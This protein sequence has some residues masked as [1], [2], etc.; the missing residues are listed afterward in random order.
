MI[1]AIKIIKENTKIGDIGY[2]IQKN[3][4]AEG[5]SVVREFC[6]HGIGKRFHESSNILHYKKQ[7][8]GQELKAGIIL[9]IE[10][11]VNT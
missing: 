5:F 8:T 10:P 7:N 6:G 11:M 2:T 4:E 9:T 1:Q 3:V